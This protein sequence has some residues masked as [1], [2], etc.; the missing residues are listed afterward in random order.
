MELS[1][2]GRHI[3]ESVAPAIRII[4]RDEASSTPTPAS[5]ELTE[6]LMDR[7]ELDFIRSVT[8]SLPPQ[9]LLE[10][11]ERMPITRIEH[12]AWANPQIGRAHV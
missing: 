12:K 10:P 11:V 7:L 4:S 6:A 8:E 3:G 9:T 1:S 5:G 2:A